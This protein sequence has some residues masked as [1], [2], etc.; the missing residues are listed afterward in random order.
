MKFLFHKKIFANQ[1]KKSP[2]V[3]YGVLRSEELISVK[4]IIKLNLCKRL[5]T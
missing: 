3:N 4:I 1:K 2:L 5:K